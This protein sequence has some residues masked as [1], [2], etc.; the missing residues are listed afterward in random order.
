MNRQR[1]TDVMQT[2][3]QTDRHATQQL[4]TDQLQLVSQV[5]SIRFLRL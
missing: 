3:R 5:Q 2:D 1:Q 4:T